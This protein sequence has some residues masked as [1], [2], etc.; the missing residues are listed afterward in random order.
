MFI[1]DSASSSID[2]LEL[3]SARLINAFDS[4]SELGS[5]ARVEALA[6][7]F[8]D[9]GLRGR[10]LRNLILC[11]AIA[12]NDCLARL[13]LRFCKIVEI[14]LCVMYRCRKIVEPTSR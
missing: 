8:V 1:S 10:K 7:V 9:Y 6:E 5:L 3:S 13:R 14:Y 12:F 4:S 11:C 2:N